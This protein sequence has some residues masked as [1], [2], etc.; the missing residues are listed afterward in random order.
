MAVRLQRDSKPRF[1]FNEVSR[2]AILSL[3]LGPEK[4]SGLPQKSEVTLYKEK[5]LVKQEREKKEEGG[6][7]SEQN[8]A[9][10]PTDEEQ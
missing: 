3:W 6:G 5:S 8:R 4:M 9:K 1:L 2:V 10:M 7:V